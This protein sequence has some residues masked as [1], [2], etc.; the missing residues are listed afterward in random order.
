M[1]FFYLRD[2]D[3]LESQRKRIAE[4]EKA[5]QNLRTEL[6]E[7]K[8]ADETLN[9]KLSLLE[10]VMQA[11][12]VML[13]LLDPQFNFVWVNSAYAKTCGMKPEE[14]VGK[15]HFS[16]YPN[17]ENEAI[18]RKVR[19]TGEKVFYK[20]KPFFFP[21]QSERGV[22]YW[23]WSLTPLKDAYGNVTG[24]VFSLRETTK[25]KQVEEA[26]RESEER[27]RL[28]GDNLPDSA[29]Y[30]YVYELDGSVRFLYISTGIERL[31]GVSA[32]DVLQDPN[33]LYRQVLPEYLERLFEAE[34]LSAR[35]LSDFDMELPMQLP[36][37]Q[38]R[39]MRLH[40]RPRRMSDGRVIWNGVQID[41]TERKRAEEALKKV[42]ERL[43]EKVKERTEELE[44]AYNS[45]K[46]SE[47]GLAEAQKIAHI[48]NWEW[49]FVT[50]E[51]YWSDELYRIF[52][53]NSQEAGASY[54]K[55]L[56]YVHPEDRDYVDNAIKRTLNEQP[57]G[58]DYRIILPNGEER[59]VHSQ[60]ELTFD[61]KNIP[62]RAKGIV[63]DITERK[64]AEEALKNLETIRKKEIH[65][66]IK[67][68]LQVISSLLDLQ[69]EKFKN[70][71]CIQDSEILE[72]FKESQDR[73]VSIALIHEE[74]HE[75]EG[76][77]TLNFSLY[78]QRLVENLF[79]SYSLGDSNISLNMSLKK[80]IF[81][82]MDIAVPLG[83]IVNELVSNSLKHAFPD[84]D[85][86]KIEI[87][88]FEN[89]LSS[90]KGE[91]AKK[92]T[93]Y[94]LIVSDNGVGIPENI[95]IE[96]SDTLG[97]QLVTILVD[98][99][100]GE[101]ELKGDK[102]TKFMIRFSVEEKEELVLEY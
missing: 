64:K 39:W 96:S 99:L 49:D 19:D 18:F 102:G 77:D 1:T 92:A 78:L 95:D 90:Y 62:I 47:K 8:H 80:N 30:Q 24:L 86:G 66:R 25:Y 68:N 50:G 41:V 6:L 17:A 12:D 101:I 40:S 74:L 3:E 46:E 55:L 84:R 15:N 9:R 22:T 89:K 13:V 88:L 93:T 21:D 23:D 100:D 33:T 53:R 79:Q 11:T 42:H 75:G 63:Q 67:N 58:I 83:M 71:K 37:G 38:I 2:K 56:K 4:L 45:L 29:L 85:K 57:L 61:E 72:A 20:D 97:L 36:S 94:T 65:H 82:D 26:L 76:E 43:E 44:K 59:T 14:M 10:S 60:A 51:V 73:V 70:R 91:F 52:G 48:G 28:L 16:L 32:Q 5:N 69:A 27:L 87:K 34:S 54:E 81:F 35:E 7:C 31:N 98:Q